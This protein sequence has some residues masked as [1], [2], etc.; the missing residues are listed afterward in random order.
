MAKSDKDDEVI[1]SAPSDHESNSLEL[2]KIVRNGQTAWAGLHLDYTFR[3]V[4]AAGAILTLMLNVV[5]QKELRDYWVVFLVLALGVVNIVL[6]YVAEKVC[7]RAYQRFLEEVTIG[8]KLEAILGFH[9]DRPQSTSTV[10]AGDKSILPDRWI[11][12]WRKPDQRLKSKEIATAND[13]VDLSMNQGVNR[14]SRIL[15]RVFLS[16]NVVVFVIAIGKYIF[17]P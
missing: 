3:F 4:V 13:F 11:E 1:T 9:N 5:S 2:Y 12:S 10:F 8:T 7:D 15:F 14:Y 6:C 17:D 16:A